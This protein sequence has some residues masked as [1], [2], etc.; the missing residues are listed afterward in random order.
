M[1]IEPFLLFYDEEVAPDDKSFKRPYNLVKIHLQP[2]TSDELPLP[3]DATVLTGYNLF[4][5]NCKTCHA[6]SGIGGTM[7][8]ELNSPKSVTEYWKTDDLVAFIVNPSAYRD[9]VK[10]PTLGITTEQSKEI[11]SY[12]AYV[13]GQKRTP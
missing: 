2:A 11:V 6:I 10:M 12:L 3:T 13:S 5:T 1:I 4:N 9:K 8:P 7:G